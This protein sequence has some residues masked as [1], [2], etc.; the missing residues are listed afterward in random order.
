MPS[1]PVPTLRDA[2]ALH[3]A[4]DL[5]GAERAYEVLLRDAPGDAEA[6]QFLGV[7]RQQQGRRGEAIALLER[8]LSIAPSNL[9]C[10]NNLGNALHASGRHVDA[11]GRTAA[12]GTIRRL[13]HCAV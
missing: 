9:A 8:A 12:R 7:L 3:R 6:L 10:L 5:A 1:A 4:G 2:K 11:V 13:L